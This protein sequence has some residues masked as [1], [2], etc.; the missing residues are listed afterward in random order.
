S[1][2]NY[3]EMA[4]PLGFGTGA[5]NLGSIALAPT[6]FP[7]S[8]LPTGSN[9]EEESGRLVLEL[10]FVGWALSLLMRIAMAIWCINLVLRGM[11]RS[12]RLAAALALPFM[13]SGVHSGNGVFAP[14]Y[15]AVAYWFFVALLAMAQYESRRALTVPAARRSESL[16]MNR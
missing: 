8:W 11:T 16:A 10:G 15:M 13:L 9:F 3:F 12:S 4:G 5:A 2:F 7:F 6:D 1:A 14:S